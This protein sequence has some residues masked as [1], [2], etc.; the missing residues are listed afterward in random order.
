MFIMKKLP[1]LKYATTLLTVAG[2]ALIISCANNPQQ[3][4]DENATATDTTAINEAEL[5]VPVVEEDTV[6]P[7]INYDEVH[8]HDETPNHE[9][10]I[11]LNPGEYQAGV[12]LDSLEMEKLYMPMLQP[13]ISLKQSDPKSYWFIVSWL[14]TAY[15]TPI[16]SGYSDYKTWQK[17]ALQAGVDCSGFTRVMC[18]RVFGTKV[19]GGSHGIYNNQCEKITKEE[20][21]KGDLLFFRAPYSEKGTRIVHV[22]VYLFDGYFVHATSTKSASRGLGLMINSLHEENWAVEFEGAGRAPAKS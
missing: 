21:Q 18:D 20:L 12:F 16:W 22:G 9:E 14:N 19:S 10:Y 11:T 8:E 4:Q 7:D 13:I 1:L 6:D 5:E 3:E 15:K 17:N 2:L